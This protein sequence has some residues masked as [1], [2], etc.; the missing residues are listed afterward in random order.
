MSQLSQLDLFGIAQEVM[1]ASAQRHK[2][3]RPKKVD[4]RVVT[5]T[6]R[7]KTVVK[8]YVDDQLKH[9]HFIQQ[10]NVPESE[11]RRLGEQ[12]NKFANEPV[13]EW[14]YMKHGMNGLMLADSL[15]AQDG[16]TPP[17]LADYERAYT[18]LTYCPLYVGD[19]RAGYEL[20]PIG[21]VNL[22]EAE[23]LPDFRHEFEKQIDAQYSQAKR[24][25][26]KALNDGS[27]TVAALKAER[28]DCAHMIV[29]C[30]E[31]LVRERIISDMKKPDMTREDLLERYP[32]YGHLVESVLDFMEMLKVYDDATSRVWE[33]AF[34]E[35][36]W[37]FGATSEW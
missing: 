11:F 6:N 16:R 37:P 30:Q 26:M 34:S 28:P 19:K 9:A 23:F 10:E 5:L 22:F 2:A 13:L 29:Y 35:T 20:S 31:C 8:Q 27:T 25:I 33:D 32:D 4:P 15:A 18:T 14:L 12:A 3:P 17:G 7:I 36:R 21:L 24:A 1:G